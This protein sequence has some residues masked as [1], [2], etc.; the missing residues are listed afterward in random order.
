MTGSLLFWPVAEGDVVAWFGE[1]RREEL[2]TVTAENPE[3]PVSAKLLYQIATG[4][5]ADEEPN[6]LSKLPEGVD[7]VLVGCSEAG[8]VHTYTWKT[9]ARA[10]TLRHGAEQI[11]FEFEFGELSPCGTDYRVLVGPAPAAGGPGQQQTVHRLAQLADV[12]RDEPTSTAVVNVLRGVTQWFGL[13]LLPAESRPAGVRS[14][15]DLWQ[16]LPPHYTTVESAFLELLIGAAQNAAGVGAQQLASERL[17][18]ANIQLAL[19]SLY[20]FATTPLGLAARETLARGRVVTPAD[21]LAF[22]PSALMAANGSYSDVSGGV[23]GDMTLL[24]EVSRAAAILGEELHEAAPASFPRAASSG[25]GSG[26]GAEGPQEQLQ[27]QQHMQQQQVPPMRMAPRIRPSISGAASA[28][29]APG[30]GGLAAPGLGRSSFAARATGASSGT[31]LPEPRLGAVESGLGNAM[32]EARASAAAM[33]ARMQPDPT[34]QAPLQFRRDPP[35]F[36]SQGPGAPPP[37][38]EDMYEV[39]EFEGAGGAGGPAAA[40]AAG[41]AQAQQHELYAAAKTDPA[42]AK[43]IGAAHGGVHENI[44]RQPWRMGGPRHFLAGSGFGLQ[45]SGTVPQLKAGSIYLDRAACNGLLGD[46][47]QLTDASAEE[48][49]DLAR[50]AQIYGSF[51]GH[52]VAFDL[53]NGALASAELL[54]AKGL[55]VLAAADVALRERE[56][57]HEPGIQLLRHDQQERPAQPAPPEFVT[58]AHLED[59]RTQLIQ[60]VTLSQA[61]QCYHLAATHSRAAELQRRPIEIDATSGMKALVTDATAANT[62]KGTCFPA[63]NTAGMIGAAASF[64]RVLTAVMRPAPAMHDFVYLTKDGAT[65]GPLAAASMEF[66][67]SKDAVRVEGAMATAGTTTLNLEFKP[68]APGAAPEEWGTLG[69]EYKRVLAAA[70][71]STGV[72]SATAPESAP[73]ATVPRPAPGQEDQ[74]PFPTKRQRQRGVGAATTAAIERVVSQALFSQGQLRQQFVP[75][76]GPQQFA[77]MLGPPPQPFSFAQPFAPPPPA[78]YFGPQQGSAPGQYGGRGGGG[79]GRGGR[80]RGGGQG[81]AGHGGHA[82]RGGHVHGYG[83]GQQDYGGQSYYE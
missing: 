64:S 2:G 12:A 9:G 33:R 79:G 82:Q 65:N 67:A 76:G 39:D 21:M 22:S 16:I 28:R 46:F 35:I 3:L 31:R 41:H 81:G 43:L 23:R 25:T 36:P 77:P 7:C 4:L 51:I 69:G 8:A 56:A 47:S 50:Q 55:D 83:G 72:A 32:R 20:A 17:S 62:K 54:L 29:L 60:H 73:P 68:H 63:S 57:R 44:K 74:F 52:S 27:L 71:G 75:L 58:R 15:F 40:P 42:F 38:D 26:Q 70:G 37:S 10:G 11:T 14:L 13:A 19:E 24:F 59:F 78:P 5:R 66:L 48:R 45:G 18:D 80:G 49:I 1:N 53:S 6:A 34:G 30:P 61:Q